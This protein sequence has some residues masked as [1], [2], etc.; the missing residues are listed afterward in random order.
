MKIPGLFNI[1]NALGAVLAAIHLG[2]KFEVEAAGAEV[3]PAPSPAAARIPV[4]REIRSAPMPPGEAAPMPAIRVTP[5]L[6]EQLRNSEPLI[7]T[8]MD[9][10]GAEIVKVE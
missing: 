2:V 9:E 3:E 1:S 8:L 10:L 7:K 6:R 4:R 5:E